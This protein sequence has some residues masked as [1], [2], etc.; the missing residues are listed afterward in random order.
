MLHTAI[1]LLNSCIEVSPT[2]PTEF[3]IGMSLY[4]GSI[5]YGLFGP[6]GKR[7]KAEKSVKV[8]DAKTKQ[9]RTTENLILN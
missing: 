3:F 7:K 1:I 6:L 8:T 2:T 4:V 5:V 9:W